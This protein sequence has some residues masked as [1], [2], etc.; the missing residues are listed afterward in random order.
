MERMKLYE[1]LVNMNGI[2]GHERQVRNFVRNELEKVSDEII[3]D[4]LG[5]VFG[6]SKGDGPVI[7]IAGHMDEV[8][9]MVS[10]I[11]DEGFIKMIA[12][13][14]LDPKVMY[15]QNVNVV[16]NDNKVIKGVIG[17]I[18]PHL[19]RGT[20]EKE[21]TFD[22]LLLD[23]GASSLAEAEAM[24]IRLGQQIVPV[25]NYY[26]MENGNRIVS[27]AWDDRFGVGMAIEKLVVSRKRFLIFLFVFIWP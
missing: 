25:N 2:A 20:T 21:L 3:Q 17:A 6:V 15:S 10:K 8:G 24:G 7:M 19:T 11:T 16:I 5:S 12:I 27:K 1:Q 4:K 18:P 14:G 13:G 26:V 22:D 9:A 23:V